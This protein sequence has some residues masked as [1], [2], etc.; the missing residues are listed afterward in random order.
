[1][2]LVKAFCI[3]ALLIAAVPLIGLA[4]PDDSAREVPSVDSAGIKARNVIDVQSVDDLLANIESLSNQEE[5]LPSW[6][7]NEIG[8]LPYARNV[9]VSGSVVGYVVD[10]ECSAALILLQQSLSEKGWKAV[11][12]GEVEGATFIKSSGVC[13]WALV[14]CTQIDNATSVVVR[15][16]VA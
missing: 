7:E 8:L 11:S 16:N 13:T 14:T 2:R 15:C 10:E 12:L 4:F 5:S 3:V 6:F 9:R 1:M